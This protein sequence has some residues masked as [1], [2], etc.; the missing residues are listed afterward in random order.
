[1]GTVTKTIREVI[2]DDPEAALRH[3]AR[4]QMYTE[5]FEKAV[6]EW[7][8]R[9][10]E[11]VSN[12]KSVKYQ[13]RTRDYVKLDSEK[14]GAI[15][16]QQGFDLMDIADVRLTEESIKAKLGEVDGNK[17]ISELIQAGAVKVNKITYWRLQIK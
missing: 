15:L 6:K 3:L 5:S 2:E 1:M 4:M 11:Y 17:V 10:G 16:E 9:N 12:N 13:R 8:E 7:A 14:A